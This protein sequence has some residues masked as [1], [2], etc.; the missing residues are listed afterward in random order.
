MPFAFIGFTLAVWYENKGFELKLFLA[1]ILCMVFARSAAMAFNRFIDA[2]FDALNPRTAS[3]E[4]PAGIIAKKNA[5]IFIVLNCVCFISTTWFIN[6]ICF[7]LSPVALFTILFY[8][9]TK[10]F[11]A[12]CHLVL[13][14]GLALAPIGAF[15]AVTNYFSL[16]PILFSF[17]VL[18]WVSGFDILYALQD[19]DFDKSQTLHS[20]PVKFGREGA[21]YL[22]VG[23]H[24][25]T[26][27]IVIA[28]GFV[29]GFHFIYWVGGMAF[30]GL[31]IY[32]HWI[33]K[34][35]D[36]SKINIAFATANGIAGIAFAIFTI[37]AIWL[38]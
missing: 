8:S 14:I 20:I 28:I 10:R 5:L 7:W 1:V 30:I 3:R 18:T 29:A 33:V 6:S 12:L 9:Y 16:M 25:I 38:M 4:I 37:W 27:L 24:V 26:T 31:L 21:I 15:L 2:G 19:E 11:T 34:P 32:Q 35:T 23:L 22:S 17:V 36:I 13:G